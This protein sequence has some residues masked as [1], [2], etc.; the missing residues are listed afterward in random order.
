MPS[1]LNT[2]DDWIIYLAVLLHNGSGD[3]ILDGDEGRVGHGTWR[4]GMAH[5][6]PPLDPPLHIGNVLKMCGQRVHLLKLLRGQGLPRSQLN[7]V[8][9]A[10]ALSYALPVWSGFRPMSVELKIQVNSFLKSA[11]KCGFCS[12]FYTIEENADDADIDLDLLVFSNCKM[13]NPRRHC[14]VLILGVHLLPCTPSG[15]AY[16]EKEARWSSKINVESSGRGTC[17]GNATRVPGY[18]K[19][20][21]NPPVFKPVNPGLFAD[22]NPGLTGLISGVSTHTECSL[23]SSCTHICSQSPRYRRYSM[24]AGLVLVY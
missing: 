10:L 2:A 24:E 11:F 13:A 5:P 4:G 18:P 6:G 20:R 14:V 23:Y 19:T 9:D 21:V 15:Y 22:E 12:K 17:L 7:T 1:Q 3:W 16:A 8:F